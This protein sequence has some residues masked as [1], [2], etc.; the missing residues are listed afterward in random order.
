MS[1]VWHPNQRPIC[2]CL[3]HTAIYSKEKFLSGLNI[4][5]C[6]LLLKSWWH[7]LKDT[8]KLT[9]LELVPHPILLRLLSFLVLFATWCAVSLH[10]NHCLWSI[11]C[12]SRLAWILYRNA[13]GRYYCSYF[14]MVQRAEPQRVSTICSQLISGTAG[15]WAQIYWTPK[16]AILLS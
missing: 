9:F 3:T 10:G 15:I 8:I 7:S 14:T 6:F 4:Q 12:V 13:Q 5:K 16:L 1:K 11:S 2:Y